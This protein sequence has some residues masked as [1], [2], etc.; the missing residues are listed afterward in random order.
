[1][2]I[3]PGLEPVPEPPSE[4]DC[5]NYLREYLARM[6]T[7]CGG[8][9]YAYVELRTRF[10]LAQAERMNRKIALASGATP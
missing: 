10:P 6:R 3:M 8:I 7:V 1:M 5:L 9:D 4:E 2:R